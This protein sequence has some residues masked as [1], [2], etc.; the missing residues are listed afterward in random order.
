[1]CE[2]RNK[3]CRSE[4]TLVWSDL[5]QLSSKST[6][7]SCRYTCKKKKFV[8]EKIRFCDKCNEQI[9]NDGSARR[10]HECF[11]QSCFNSK[12]RETDH[13]CYMA[14]LSPEMPSSY[15]VL[16]EFYDF[17]TTQ[18]TK[19]T[20][21]ATVHVLNLVCVQQFCTLCEAKPDI[22]K[23]CGMCGQSKH[24]LETRP[25]KRPINLSVQALPI[26]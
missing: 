17:E 19:L 13:L 15:K 4:V 6:A 9:T 14:P 24:I 10:K 25:C 16:Y 2:A 21:S 20:E 23:Q 3:S 18:N 7:Y 11:K 1:M 12:F 22:D 8:C 26:G 5:Q